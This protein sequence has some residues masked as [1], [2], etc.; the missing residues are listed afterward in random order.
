MFCNGILWNGSWLICFW[1]QKTRICSF[2]IW[3]LQNKKSTIAYLIQT[4]NITLMQ[5][6]GKRKSTNH[7]PR[8]PDFFAGPK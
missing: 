6:P 5:V 3:E 1:K 7:L 8:A 2:F 4:L